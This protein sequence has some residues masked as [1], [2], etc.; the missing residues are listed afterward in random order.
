MAHGSFTGL[1]SART[2]RGKLPAPARR[3]L[4]LPEHSRSALFA[5]EVRA[6]LSKAGWGWDRE[7]GLDME[8][9]GGADIMPPPPL[10]RVKGRGWLHTR[11]C[12][13]RLPGTRRQA[14]PMHRCGTN[15]RRR[16]EVLGATT[17]CWLPPPALPPPRAVPP[18]NQAGCVLG[19]R[20]CTHTPASSETS[21]RKEGNQG[22]IAT[23]VSRFFL[24]S[25]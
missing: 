25:E 3:A 23:E 5:S 13:L 10:T 1:S 15:A 8:T 21:R 4:C 17:C 20:E 22:D 6:V 18:T 24:P 14:L 9:S 2:K 11:S 16:R 12:G 7:V 19:P